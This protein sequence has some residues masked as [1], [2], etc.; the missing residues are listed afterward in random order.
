MNGWTFHYA[1]CTCDAFEESTYARGDS[2]RGNLKLASQQGFLD[3]NVLKA[4]VCNAER[5]KN[6]PI[7]FLQLLLPI[8]DP[9][10]SGVANDDCIP[11]F[12]HARACTNVYALGEKGWGGGMGHRFNNVEEAELVTWMGA[13]IRHGAREG[14][15]GSLNHRWMKA[16][17]NYDD[18]IADNMTASRFKQIKSVFK[19]NYNVTA[20]KKN[21]DDYD[22]AAKYD[23]IYKTLC[24]NMNYVTGRAGADFA[25]DETAWDFTG[26][27]GDA[28]GRLHNK[29][30]S[31]GGQ[32][33]MVFDITWQYPRFYIY[34]HKRHAHPE[35]FNTEGPSEMHYL[36][37]VI[38][39]HVAGRSDNHAKF[40]I[41]D[42]FGHSI[43]YEQNYLWRTSIWHGG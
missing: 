24:H 31:K 43:I 13:I 4:H 29:P 22:P 11:F 33:T 27:C 30:K 35:G 32:T 7:F 8:C 12:Q 36:L 9:L 37:H 2:K 18:V 42:G 20:K 10:R 41:D 21:D 15:P 3:V 19:L 25:I 28:G 6:D 39:K 38:N 5:I 1:G 40:D 34:R 26:Y 23:H 17:P 14:N 16:H